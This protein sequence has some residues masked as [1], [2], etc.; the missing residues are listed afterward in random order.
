MDQLI[1]AAKRRKR[2]LRLG[3]VGLLVIFLLCLA[4]WGFRSLVKPV[5]VVGQFELATVEIGPMFES[6]T[7]TGKVELENHYTILAPVTAVLKEVKSTSGRYVSIGDTLLVLDDTPLQKAYNDKLL[8]MESLKNKVRKLQLTSKVEEMD[9]EFAI[10]RKKMEIDRAQ[11]ELE[12][13]KKIAKMGGSTQYTVRDMAQKLELLQAEHQLLNRKYEIK[14]ETLVASKREIDIEVSQETGELRAI[15]QQITE[16]IVTAPVS[17]VV[18][19]VNGETGSMVTK[20]KELARISDLSTYK[21]TGKVN[22]AL[23]EQVASGGEVQI[24]IDSKTKTGGII[25]NI[26]PVVEENYVYFDIFPEEKDH[27]KFRPGMVVEIRI[28]TTYKENA[29]RIKDGLFYDGSKN[30]KVFRVEDD[31][32]MAVDVETGMKNMDYIEITDG[33]KQGDKVVIS[34]VTEINHL[35]EVRIVKEN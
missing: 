13:E 29:L 28:I 4:F 33:L 23:S 20:D 19:T 2:K 31:K 17:G 21:I 7:T 22:N 32:A 1:P 3:G 25:G 12:D 15:Q 14:K 30:I 27:P 5:L 10:K 18:V 8:Q 11:A 6:V 34:D 26:R 9:T 16:L 35:N 24:I